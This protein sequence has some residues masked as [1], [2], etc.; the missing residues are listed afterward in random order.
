MTPMRR[1]PLGATGLG[2]FMILLDALIA[3]NFL[4]RTPKDAYVLTS[5]SQ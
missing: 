1:C 4:K 2:L 3:T 5:E